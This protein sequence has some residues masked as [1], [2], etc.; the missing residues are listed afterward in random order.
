MKIKINTKEERY[1]D[2]TNRG[3]YRRLKNKTNTSGRYRVLKIFL[4]K[5]KRNCEVIK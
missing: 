3:K 2:S 5:K 1:N 4:D